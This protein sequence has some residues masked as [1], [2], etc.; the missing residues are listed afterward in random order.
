MDL[1]YHKSTASDQPKQLKDNHYITKTNKK[2]I[3]ISIDLVLEL[4]TRS[5]H[6]KFDNIF[7]DRK[8]H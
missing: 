6:L 7:K 2:Q 4:I 3:I 5:D 8:V 1:Q